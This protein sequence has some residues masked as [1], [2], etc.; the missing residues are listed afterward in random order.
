MDEKL[1]LTEELKNPPPLEMSLPIAT[2]VA[3][4]VTGSIP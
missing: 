4:P 1:K 3:T 2:R